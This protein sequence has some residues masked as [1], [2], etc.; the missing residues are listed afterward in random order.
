MDGELLFQLLLPIAW[1]KTQVSSNVL[2]NLYYQIF[3]THP[4]TTMKNLW[5]I[6]L[7]TEVRTWERVWSSRKCSGRETA[8]LRFTRCVDPTTGASGAVCR[9][10]PPLR[11]TMWS[12]V[13][14]WHHGR[15][16]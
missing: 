8:F 10:G 7:W 14:R 9:A 4:Q 3:H 15:P 12:P 13:A 2:G 1:R 11:V 16:R 5:R 6:M